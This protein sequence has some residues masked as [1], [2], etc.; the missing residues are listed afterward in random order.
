VQQNYV[1]G[2]LQEMSE[3]GTKNANWLQVELYDGV[4][5][6]YRLSYKDDGKIVPSQ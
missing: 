6:N 5:R 1:I 4:I 2:I 3:A